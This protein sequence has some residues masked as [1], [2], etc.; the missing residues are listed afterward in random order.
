MRNL[1]LALVTTMVRM[2]ITKIVERMRIGSRCHG[3]EEGG[4]LFHQNS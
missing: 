2:W 1:F 3:R 4:P